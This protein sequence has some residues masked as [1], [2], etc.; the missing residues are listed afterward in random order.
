MCLLSAC[1][2]LFG[3]HW[4]KS[5]IKAASSLLAPM[6]LLDSIYGLRRWA[7]TLVVG[8]GL[9]LSPALLAGN[10][11]WSSLRLHDDFYA[12]GAGFGDINGDGR[13]D[14]VS[15]P[16][17]WAGPT[18]STPRR[19]YDGEI[20]DLRRYSDNFFSYV[21]DID[22]DGDND[23]L[24]L[25]F[26]G[27]EAR[28]YLNPGNPTDNSNWN[29][30]IV[31]DQVSHESPDFVDIV[32]GGLP[33][34]VCS[35]ERA[36][37]YY[38]AG[39]NPTEPWQWVGVSEVGEAVGPFGH[40]LGLGDLDADGD[41]DILDRYSWWEN[42]GNGNRDLW[43]KSVWVLEQYERGGAQIHVHDVD[44]DGLQDIVTSLNGHGFG[45]AWF[46][47]IGMENGERKF[48]RIDIMG[49]SSAQNPFG[50]SVSQLHGVELKDIDGDGAKDI[51][52]GKRWHAHYGKD[53]GCNQEPSVYWFRAEKSEAGVEFVPYLIDNDSGVGVDVLVEDL[54]GDG[55]LDVVSASKRGV[56]IHFQKGD[57]LAAR[58]ER[59]RVPGGRPDDD[60][61]HSLSPEE[62]AAAMEVPEGF[63]VDLI[64]S[65]PDVV[66]PIA[67]CFD[68]RGRL[69]V[70]EGKTYPVRK[71]GEKGADRILI[72]E[73]KDADG[74]F[75]TKK[76][77]AE[78]LN[79]VSG[80]EVGFGG[81]WIG[82]APYLLFIPDRNGDDVADGVPEVLLDG[83]GYQDTHE[84]LNSFTWGPDGWL[85][86]CHGV[87]THS[88]VGKP[89]ATED[90]RVPINAGIWRYHP[91]KREF[92]VFA[93]GT[94]NP[95]GLDFDENGDWFTTACVIPHYYQVI[96]GGR[97]FRQAGQHFNSYVYDD[98]KTI[99]DH[100][101][102]GDGTFE[103]MRADGKVDRALQREKAADTSA[104]GGGHAHC[105]LVIY[106]ADNFP[107]AYRGDS[108]FHNLHG[109]RIVRERPEKEG[110]GTVMRH[111]PDFA[112]AQDHSFIG[113]ALVQGPDGALY[114]SDWHDPQTCHHRDPDIWNRSNG[115]VYRIRYGEYEANRV[116]LVGASDVELAEYLTHSNNF[117]ARQAQ[118]LLQEH[119][120]AGNLDSG[121]VTKELQDLMRAEQPRAHRLRA[122]WA[123]QVCGL[124]DTGDVYSILDDQD[125]YMRGWAVH[126]Y[127]EQGDG[128]PGKVAQKF[129]SL[130]K[131]DESP[132]VRR[133]LA[134][135]LQNLPEGQRWDLAEGLSSRRADINDQNLP[136]LVWYGLEPMV[137]GSPERS[138]EIAGE[139]AWPKL[140]SFTQR[141]AAETVEGRSALLAYVGRAKTSNEF[142][143]RGQRFLAAI[144]S[145]VD[146]ERPSSWDAFILGGES[147]N[148]DRVNTMVLRVRARLGD[149][150][151]FAYWRGVLNDSTRLPRL[152]MEALEIL[153]LGGDP[154]AGNGAASLL[155]EPAFRETALAALPRYMDTEIAAKLIE[156][157]PAFPL[158]LRN[159]G[160]NLLGSR[161]D[162]TLLLLDAIESKQV[163]AA[164]VSPVLMRQMRAHGDARITRKMNDLWGEPSELPP[165][166]PRQMRS[167]K[168]A[169]TPERLERVDLS[170]GRHVYSNTCG[171]CHKLFDSGVALGPDLTGSN[172]V[173]LDYILENVLAPNSVVGKDY[174][175]NVITTRDGRVFSGMVT[176]E[177][178]SRLEVSMAG[179]TK[180]VVRT[181][182]IEERKILSQSMMPTGLFDA[183][184]EDDVAALVAYLASP[185]QVDEWKG[186]K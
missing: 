7:W 51:V 141:R 67:M 114:V 183:I 2:V 143:D 50:V 179:G 88:R 147:L 115:R 71:P 131:G 87:F 40:G 1:P 34:I 22:A 110:S 4:R 46:R 47:Q 11:G 60:W 93:W 103:S 184:P 123:M 100:L 121:A 52:T 90:Q 6:K 111:A 168:F 59:W 54:N 19:F 70:A 98:I 23:I 104:L 154:Q 13:G 76:V 20:F 16:F 173:N 165:D 91:T 12:E 127:G 105:G 106:Q 14:L 33:E 94:S 162:T 151:A 27:K 152:R 79:L 161:R 44:G 116:D 48:E 125:P 107:E 169:L 156:V 86:G 144:G 83:W 112:L 3:G 172:R 101:H 142:L 133:Y 65:E 77:F 49:E 41:L 39:T 128:V 30:V 92:E 95:W 137:T 8:I 72:F 153:Q 55:R 97:Y 163:E 18:F 139:S 53:P 73:D 78:N 185:S 108:F 119:A 130:A 75:E 135:S 28:L 167:W 66:Q 149:Q 58:P 113:V 138:I 126:F 158:K 102:Y 17:W 37:G 38:Q 120:H 181:A 61:A 29:M 42:P 182:D 21:H 63:Y 69:W 140:D 15:G 36:F 170:Y 132:V 35:R 178:G 62:A 89:G 160:I 174:Q 164:L 10:N 117:I 84:T 96:Q 99:A 150:S 166:F 24:V 25:G 148:H 159:E 64:A 180:T 80:I 129:V 109:H 56:S 85:Y 145:K 157:L 155:S 57:I 9:N 82:A 74:E 43:K 68:A 177:D 45:L 81:V 124:M 146:L 134:S 186:E 171:T 26:P 176:N 5:T 122:F 31:A 136:L 118:L 175:L 32:P